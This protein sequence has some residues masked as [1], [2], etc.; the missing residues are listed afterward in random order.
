V[1]IPSVPKFVLEL[2]CLFFSLPMLAA[3]GT[4]QT[5]QYLARSWSV[6]EGLPH[7]FVQAVAQTR[8]GYIWVGTKEGLARFD[9][10]HFTKMDS[11]IFPDE[12][13][14][15]ITDLCESRDGSFWIATETNGLWCWN[16]RGRTFFSQ[17]N[18]LPD[19]KIKTIYEAR[20][21][22]IWV[23]T[24]NGLSPI[25]NGRVELTLTKNDGLPHNAI[26]HLCEDQQGN[27]CIATGGGVAFWNH[28]KLSA[29]AVPPSPANAILS[30]Q[31]ENLWVGINKGLQQIHRDTVTNYSR[32]DGITDNFVSALHVDRGGRLWI[33]TYGG[34][35]YRE[36]KTIFTETL[37]DGSPYDAVNVIFED[38]EDNLWLGTREG[39][40]CLRRRPVMMLTKKQGLTHDNVTSVME[41]DYGRFLIGTWGGGLNRWI[42][43]RNDFT[44]PGGWKSELVLSICKSKDLWF[45]ADYNH[46]LYRW[47]RDLSVHY[48]ASEGLD[49]SAVRVI[50]EDRAHDLWIGTSRS[51]FR[52]HDEKFTRFT[53]A[54]G[55]AGETVRVILQ[56]KAGD[57]WIGTHGG[58]SRWRD[59]KFTNFTQHDGLSDNTI[60]A[61]HEDKARTLWIGTAGGGLNCLRHGKFHFCGTQHGL[62]TDTIFEI[63]EDHRGFLWMSSPNGIFRVN[64]RN[65]ENFVDAK[66]NAVVCNS[67]GKADGMESPRCNGISK[68][69]SWK[70][71]DGR[72]WFATTKGVAIVD[73][74][75]IK[76]NQ[77]AP[78]VV[79]EEVMAD[80]KKIEDGGL[81][82]EDGKTDASSPLSSILHSPSSLQILPGRG[83]LEIHFTALSYTV[84]E[85]NR[86]KYKL[87][88]VDSDWVDAGTR[89]F[90]YY[91][92]VK[93]GAYKFRVVACN[94]DSV[95]NSIGASVDLT[96]QP[97]LWQTRWFIGSIGLAAIGFIGGTARYITRKRLQRKFERLEQQ[98]A[99]EKE[100]TR[101]AKDMHD[102]L[103]ARLTEIMFL[104]GAVE[105]SPDAGP[106]TKANVTKA[107]ETARELVQSLDAIVWA[108]EPRNDTLENLAAYLQDY[109]ER[110]LNNSGIQCFFDVQKDLPP[111]AISSEVRH[112]IFLVTKEALNN[113]AKHS[114]ATEVRFSLHA[115][116]A[117]LDISMQDNGKGFSRDA[118]S[119]LSNGLHNMDERLKNIGSHCVISSEP[120]KGTRVQMGIAI[121][122]NGVPE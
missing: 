67:F 109:A 52:F 39:L 44:P 62:F 6:D 69:A 95:W 33:G 8:D 97:H 10:F 48:G 89:R 84:P 82:T 74:K 106:Q 18:G 93:P 15:S 66:T 101:I 68:P 11:R 38:R 104:N 36:N 64:K 56:D 41:D 61:L 113:I 116:A 2:L 21:G 119:S 16:D 92:N 88:G 45:G 12:K 110:F 59:G 70:A 34:L 99:I 72:L 43:T 121:R 71:R 81:T 75:L 30:D 32:T 22:A 27:L 63:L 35:S 17:T 60:L 79:I 105:Q 100:R 96:L 98:H 9:G 108:V 37:A 3:P 122:S 78:P 40:V 28:G 76:L 31:D 47:N 112:N 5:S 19:N 77:T 117:R 13:P 115:A 102:D 53:T 49:N 118:V 85:K 7:S 87:E 25:K 111:R 73:P 55:L 24:A 57:L 91:N 103:G 83:E 46:G 107:A 54:D 114:G 51:L 65:L 1:N 14:H 90:A 29:P 4:N 94:N 80:K 20:D 26:R 120:G 23:G 50:Y 86:F 42:G 58:L